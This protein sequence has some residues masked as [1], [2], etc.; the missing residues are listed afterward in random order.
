MLIHNYEEIFGRNTKVP[1]EFSD[2]ASESIEAYVT[3]LI[4]RNQAIERAKTLS[5]IVKKEE[6]VWPKLYLMKLTQY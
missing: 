1:L 5:E 6:K 4:D 3:S 2:T